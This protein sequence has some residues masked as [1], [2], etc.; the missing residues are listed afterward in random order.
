[1]ATQ[2]LSKVRAAYAKRQANPS[3]SPYECVDQSGNLLFHK[4]HKAFYLKGLQVK[5]KVIKPGVYK[6][7]DSA[8]STLVR[9]WIENHCDRIT[10]YRTF[11]LTD[12]FERFVFNGKV[13]TPQV[14][15][16]GQ[17]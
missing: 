2:A 9:R 10:D 16:S 11:K 7:V 8:K 13:Y 17:V 15:M 6:K 1:M 12:N 3:S 4:E 5:R 14:F